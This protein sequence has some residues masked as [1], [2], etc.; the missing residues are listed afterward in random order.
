MSAGRVTIREL[1]RVGQ[2]TEVQELA[3]AAWGFSDRA[4]PAVT[5][6]VAARHVGGLMA[7]AFE[8]RRMV[9]FV[10]G[11]PR[12]NLAEPCHHSHMLAVHP[13]A[14]GRGLS[15]RL[16]FFQRRWCLRRGIRLMTWTFDPL[17]VKNAHLNL[18]KLRARAHVYIRNFYGPLG[19]IYQGLPTDRFEMHWRLDAPEVEAAARGRASAPAALASWP[20]AGRAHLP[21]AGRVAVEIPLGAPALYTRDPRAARAARLRLR[22]QAEVLFA[23]GY[24]ATALEVL[25]GCARYGFTRR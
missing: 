15:A 24:Q 14:Q 18:V 21:R 4:L 25:A 19:G 7:A 8:G 6:L 1:D 12:T 20:L 23:R 10:Q 5:D 9:G 11:L 2:L 13:E 16:K 17:I 22:R 3:R